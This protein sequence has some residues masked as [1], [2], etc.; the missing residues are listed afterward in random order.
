[1]AP[2]FPVLLY[3][4]HRSCSED[5]GRGLWVSARSL[6]HQC[7]CLYSCF[8]TGNQPQI[9]SWSRACASL[10]SSTCVKVACEPSASQRC[11]FAPLWLDAALTHR[12]VAGRSWGRQ[13]RQQQR[14]TGLK[15][16]ASRTQGDLRF[17]FLRLGFCWLFF[18]MHT[19]RI[20]ESEPERAAWRAEVCRFPSVGCYF[21]RI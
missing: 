1:M 2:S 15:R 9:A 21:L 20:S 8:L 17:E 7:I 6:C 19:A 18:G 5:Q 3:L 11:Q 16:C 14:C 10:H 13:L 12:Q 4:C